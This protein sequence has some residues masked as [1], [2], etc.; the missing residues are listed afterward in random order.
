[1]DEKRGPSLRPPL[2]GIFSA[3]NLDRYRYLINVCPVFWEEKLLP[4]LKTR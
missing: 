1:M 4:A 3:S 2:E